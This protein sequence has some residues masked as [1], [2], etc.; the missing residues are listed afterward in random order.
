MDQMIAGFEGYE[1]IPKIFLDILG[2]VNKEEESSVTSPWSQLLARD[3]SGPKKLVG[4]AIDSFTGHLKTSPFETPEWS[5]LSQPKQ[6]PDPAVSWKTFRSAEDIRK[7]VFSTLTENSGIEARVNAIAVP[8]Y[9]YSFQASDRTLSVMMKWVSSPRV[10]KTPIRMLRLTEA[11]AAAISIGDATFFQNHGDRFVSGWT[12][13]ATVVAI[14]T[15]EASRRGNEFTEWSNKIT[16]YFKD[17]K[18]LQEGC[19][20]LRDLGANFFVDIFKSNSESDTIILAKGHVRPNEVFANVDGLKETD[21]IPTSIQL[22]SYDTIYPSYKSPAPELPVNRLKK[23][24]D[25]FQRNIMLHVGSKASPF[26]KDSPQETELRSQ[27][28]DLRSKLEQGWDCFVIGAQGADDMKNLE[29]RHT[30]NENQVMM[31]FCARDWIRK[32]MD[33]EDKDEAMSG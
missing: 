19:D 32:S 13:Q 5:D 15:L 4:H 33:S 10:R 16:E 26:R 2:R 29:S 31:R 28:W 30:E 27:V 17:T 20:F 7:E 25:L 9:L 3:I 6:E 22:M 12:E 8:G 14:W 1:K 11:A 21:Y 24:R 18:N 23:V